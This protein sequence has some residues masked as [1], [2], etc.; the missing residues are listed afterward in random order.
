MKFTKS[1]AA[2]FPVPTSDS[3]FIC[4]GIHAPAS[5]ALRTHGYCSASCHFTL[6]PA[7]TSAHAHAHLSGLARDAHQKN[8]DAVIG[9]A[10]AKAG[11]RAED[12][13]AVAVTL[14]PGLEICLRVGANAARELARAH[15]LPFVAVHHLEV[16]ILCP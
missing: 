9:T 7:H 12:L 16:R 4:V 1:S 3:C 8:V 5:V 15:E 6:T 10:L 14:G 11:M 13:D 2:L